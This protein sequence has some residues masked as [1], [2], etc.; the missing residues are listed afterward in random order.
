[1][2][3][4]ILIL[5]SLALLSPVAQAEYRNGSWSEASIGMNAII[6]PQFQ[7]Q[8]MIKFGLGLDRIVLDAQFGFNLTTTV[9]STLLQT[10]GIGAKIFVWNGPLWKIED[11]QVFLIG[12]A[13]SEA[14]TTDIDFKTGEIGA[15]VRPDFKVG[16]KVM[17]E[18]SA[19]W[20]AA[21]DISAHFAVNAAI[22]FII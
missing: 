21:Q 14:G 17:T 3:R 19:V 22:V 7:Y 5:A 8:P 9:D 11:L 2:K 15:G 4:L 16:N 10:V 13:R 1:M 18:F 12:T 6:N 20:L